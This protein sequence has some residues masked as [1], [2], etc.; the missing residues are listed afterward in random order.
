MKPDGGLHVDRGEMQGFRA[1]DRVKVIEGRYVGGSGEV[2]GWISRVETRKFG[3]DVVRA[4]TLYQVQ[5]D[6]TD[7][8]VFVEETRLTQNKQ[9]D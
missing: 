6:Q 4:M 2:F 1:G 5:L 7:E 8:M 3:D 9:C